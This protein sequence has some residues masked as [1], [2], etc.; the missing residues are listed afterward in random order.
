MGGHSK[1]HVGMGS[2]LL[3]TPSLINTCTH[4]TWGSKRCSHIPL[5]LHSPSELSYHPLEGFDIPMVPFCGSGFQ[6]VGARSWE[7]GADTGSVD[8]MNCWKV[9]IRY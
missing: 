7:E 3:G 8:K 4:R 1:M 6:E 9:F 2:F 5:P